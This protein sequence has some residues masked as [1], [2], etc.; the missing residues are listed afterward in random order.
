MVRAMNRRNCK[1]FNIHMHQIYLLT[2]YFSIFVYCLFS[3]PHS[4]HTEKCKCVN[5]RLNSI[6][7]P[8]RFRLTSAKR[9][10]SIVRNQAALVICQTELLSTRTGSGK[11]LEQ[12]CHQLIV[13]LFSKWA[14]NRFSFVRLFSFFLFFDDKTKLH[15]H[16]D[17][18]KSWTRFWW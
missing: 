15:L 7:P 13:V 12:N 9:G 16:I 18:D 11:H 14:W 17:D 3:A 10:Q 2:L 8:T 1:A 6:S 5:V 4:K